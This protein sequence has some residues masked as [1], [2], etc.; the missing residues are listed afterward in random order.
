MRKAEERYDFEAAAFA[1]SEWT[2]RGHEE[3]RAHGL[4]VIADYVRA[5][6]EN[7]SDALEWLVSKNRR[8]GVWCACA[9]AREVLECVPK[10]NDRPRIAIET[11]EDWVR[12]KVT[13]RKV[14]NADNDVT[15][16]L[17]YDDEIF[18]GASS[19]ASYA[20]WTAWTNDP[21]SAVVSARK[22]AYLSAETEAAVSGGYLSSDDVQSRLVDVVADAIMT[23]PQPTRGPASLFC[24]SRSFGR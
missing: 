19:A 15:A 6:F 4:R 20:A 8:L 11:T 21:I 7:A 9:V 1:L 14:I 10:R 23:F 22:T 18:F 24:I 2:G 5:E 3:M 17:N 13:K 12:G 16:V